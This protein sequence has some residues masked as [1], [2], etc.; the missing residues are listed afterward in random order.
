MKRKKIW[1]KFRFRESNQ[2]KSHNTAS[3]LLEDTKIPSQNVT[4]KS[5]E[6]TPILIKRS[7]ADVLLNG[8]EVVNEGAN[9]VKSVEETKIDERNITD[10]RAMRNKNKVKRRYEIREILIKNQKEKSRE[11]FRDIP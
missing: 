9:E 8:N 4:Q 7:Y 2:N 6:D 10:N 11:T 1:D 5:L 3:L